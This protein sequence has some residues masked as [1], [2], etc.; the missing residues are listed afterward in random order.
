MIVSDIFGFIDLLQTQTF[1]QGDL[2]SHSLKVGGCGIGVGMNTTTL[3]N[4]ASVFPVSTVTSARFPSNKSITGHD[5]DE[6]PAILDSIRSLA[7]DSLRDILMQQ[8]G[9]A[10]L[11]SRSENGHDVQ[12]VFRIGDRGGAPL[13]Q[14]PPVVGC[15][16]TES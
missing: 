10:F 1:P 15:E 9:D 16:P 12:V 8:H 6:N 5:P 4:S 13:N 11:P 7:P 3:A 2:T 14:S